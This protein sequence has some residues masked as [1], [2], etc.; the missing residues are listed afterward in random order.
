MHPVLHDHLRSRGPTTPGHSM[1]LCENRSAKTSWSEL[2]GSP[3]SRR[4]RNAYNELEQDVNI[5]LTWSSAV[6]LSLSTTPK[7]CDAS[8]LA[9][10]QAWRGKSYRLVSC[11]A[12]GKYDF[13][14]FKQFSFKLFVSAQSCTC[15]SSLALVSE[16]TAGTI[17]YV[18]S[19]NLTS[20]L[21]TCSGWRSD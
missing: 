17:M 14:D 1:Y 19:A 9:N 2:A 16:L 5:E 8:Y 18:S 10:A 6:S 13:F 15:L 21:P 12:A 11:T 20:A 3:W 4:T 7:C